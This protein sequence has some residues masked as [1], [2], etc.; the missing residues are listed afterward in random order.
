MNFTLEN[1]VIVNGILFGKVDFRHSYH[2]NSIHIYLSSDS[3]IKI[4]KEN[5]LSIPIYSIAKA[6]K[7]KFAV[8]KTILLVGGCYLTMGIGAFI[9]ML[10]QLKK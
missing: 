9:L 7:S 10:A 4:N 3:V 1:T 8:G 2:R 5:I 6:N